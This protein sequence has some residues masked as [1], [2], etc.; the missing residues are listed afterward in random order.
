MRAELARVKLS[1]LV[2]GRPLRIEHA[3]FHLLVARVGDGL[4][5][6]EDACP[7]SGRSLSAGTLKGSVVTCP[8][9]AWQIDVVTGRVVTPAGVT[10]CNPRYDVTIEGDEAVI[11]S[12]DSAT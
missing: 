8:G 12:A 7:H 10:E 3:P 9:H 2:A 11:W 4:H 6:I 1:L 5:A